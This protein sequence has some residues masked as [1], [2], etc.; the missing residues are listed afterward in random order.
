MQFS[1]QH[2]GSFRFVEEGE[3]KKGILLLLHGLFGA[4]SNFTELI[5]HFSSQYK[6][7]I[8]FLPIYT[9]NLSE[10]NLDFLTEYVHKFVVQMKYREIV[11][12]GNSLGGHLALLYAQQ[13]A[14]NVRGMVLTG[15]SGLFENTMGDTFPQRGNYEFIKHKTEYTFYDPKTASKELIDEVFDIVNNRDKCMCVIAMAKSAI[16]HN[17]AEELPHIYVPTLLIWGKDDRVTPPFVAEDFKKLLPDSE[18]FYIEQ[19]GHAPMMEQPEEFNRILSDFL[20]RQN[21]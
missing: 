10:A 14:E 1:V 4:L 21:T 15:S 12:I 2:C 19:C 5:R 8:P 18:L 13:Y 16:R 6:V 11:L 7:V 3:D 20:D 17:M 9:G